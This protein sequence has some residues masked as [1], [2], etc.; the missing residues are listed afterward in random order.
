MRRRAV[1]LAREVLDR[2][3]PSGSGLTDYQFSGLLERAFR[4]AGAEDLRLLFSTGESAPAPAQGAKLDEEFSVA[5]ALEYRGH[6]VKVTRAWT[7]DAASKALE[8]RFI[9]TLR[10][11]IGH[12][13]NLAG[14]YPSEMGPGPIFALQVESATDDARLFYGDTCLRDE[15]GAA[16]L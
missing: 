6:W 7:S 9:A 5:V 15:L 4:R 11:G 16:L 13:E 10:A 2:E 8:D 14:P 12:I 3:L 1:R